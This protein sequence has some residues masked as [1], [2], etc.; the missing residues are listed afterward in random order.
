M[1]EKYFVRG[2]G[3]YVI[4]Y[5]IMKPETSNKKALVYLHPSGKNTE[6]EE[7][8]EIEWFV[9]KGF[10][11]LAPDLIGTGETGPEKTVFNHA[12][13]QKWF[14][15]ILI[16]R[17]IVGVRAGDLV[18][19]ANLLKQKT[20]IEIYGL[21][22]REMGPVMLHAAAFST[23]IDRIALIEPYSSYKSIVMNKFYD[24]GFI[25]GAV[26]GALKAYDLPDLAASLAP[27]K[28]LMTNVTDGNGSSK[29]REKIDQDL[30]FVRT[31]YQFRAADQELKISYPE[32]AE[33]TYDLFMQ[34][35]K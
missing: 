2:E 8:G 10:T 9:R 28:L 7:G 4:P 33:K 35:I 18:M 31:V 5:L 19:L 30:E 23:S 1:V 17:S 26:P 22:R 34:W 29:D 11:V 6:A 16:G 24:P 25:Y 13:I 12:Y 32:S 27:R 15:S 20:G 14:A 21:A 3:N